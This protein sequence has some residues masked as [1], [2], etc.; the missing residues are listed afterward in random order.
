MS[1]SD[2]LDITLPEGMELAPDHSGEIGWVWSNNIWINPNPPPP[3]STEILAKNARIKR[4]NLLRK[5][6]D[7]F[8]PLRWESLSVED[9]QLWL[10]YR[11]ALLDIPQQQEFPLNIIWPEKPGE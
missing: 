11:Q 4:N 5:N 1:L 9:K 3:I 2:T 6:I 10:D 8:N 7:I